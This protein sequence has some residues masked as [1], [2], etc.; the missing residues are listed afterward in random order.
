MLAFTLK[1]QKISLLCLFH[2]CL[3]S[4]SVAAINLDKMDIIIKLNVLTN[5]RSLSLK[6]PTA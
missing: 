4:R 1:T 2:N 6:C 5:I 3:N